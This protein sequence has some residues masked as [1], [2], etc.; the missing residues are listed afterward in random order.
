M[1]DVPRS[2]QPGELPRPLT[3]KEVL[4]IPFLPEACSHGRHPGTLP[5]QPPPATRAVHGVAAFFAGLLWCAGCATTTVATYDELAAAAR[6]GE[7]VDVGA[8]RAAFVAAPDFFERLENISPLETQAVQLI[9]EEPLRLGPLGSAIVDLYPGSLAGHQAL[10]TFYTYLDRENAAAEHRRSVSRILAVLEENASGTFESPLPVTS[11]AEPGAYLVAM[12]RTPLGSTYVPTDE[13]P[14]L[15][16]VAARDG[17]GRI[18]NVYF[19]L[20]AV[21]SGWPG[22]ANEEEDHVPPLFA[23]T[24]RNDSAAQTYLGEIFLNQHRLDEATALLTR[25]SRGGN[26]IAR[27]MLARAYWVRAANTDEGFA[28]DAARLE[29]VNNYERAIEMGSDEA[30]FELGRLYAWGAYGRDLRQNGVELLVQAADLDNSNACL[31]LA[32]W[33]EFPEPASGA[34]HDRSQRYYVRAASLD[35][36]AAKIQYA[37]FLMRDD[38]DKTFTDQAYRW[39]TKLAGSRSCDEPFGQCVEARVQLGNLFAKGVHVK[40]NYRKARSWFKSAVA[41]SP[42]RA[43][44]VNDVAWTLTVSNLE[45]LRDERYALKIM[46]HVMTRDEHARARPEYIDTWAAAYAANGDFERAIEL[47]REA[48]DQANAAPLDVETIEILRRH[49]RAFEAGRTITDPI[50]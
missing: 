48:L 46:D 21:Y 2:L 5:M 16:Q 44:V 33:F 37:R 39:L 6:A 7:D 20:D 11:R 45:R 34:D 18:E 31:T 12:G 19:D 49:L 40:R 17:D 4:A 23:L 41:A 25:A 27:I 35:N 43:D 10:A 32:R 22:A 13:I 9:E 47:Q 3:R 26:L 24:R 50:P 1:D 30:M 36:D 15:L 14:F 42:E 38:V 29:A 8:L 28:R